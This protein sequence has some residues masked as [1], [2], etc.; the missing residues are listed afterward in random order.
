[1]DTSDTCDDIG[2]HYLTESQ[3]RDWFN[4]LPDSEFLNKEKSDDHID[5]KQSD[6][7]VGDNGLDMDWSES[8][9]TEK[10][11]KSSDSDWSKPE[12]IAYKVIWK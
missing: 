9:K 7:E 1:M 11:R 2:A 8:D 4:D 5:C 10:K 3:I 6:I 12:K